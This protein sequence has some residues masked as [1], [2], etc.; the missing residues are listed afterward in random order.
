[1]EQITL[2]ETI[3][4]IKKL[5]ESNSGDTGRLQHIIDFLNK[6]KPL[7]KTDKIYLEKKIN[8]TAP[9]LFQ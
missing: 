8:S 2:E 9:E 3:K 7:Y 6:E 1:M 5:I 4:E